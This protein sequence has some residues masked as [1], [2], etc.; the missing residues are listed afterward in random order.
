MRVSK[1]RTELG[2]LRKR[3]GLTQEQMAAE[4]GV[5]KATV[6][7]IELGALKISPRLLGV[8]L[9]FSGEK[10]H[11]SIRVILEKRV[12]EFRERIYR[13]AGIPLK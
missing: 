10:A 5:S 12:Q 6:Q 3:L 1:Y 4:L 11:D 8:V 9:S 13:D 2:A 7:A